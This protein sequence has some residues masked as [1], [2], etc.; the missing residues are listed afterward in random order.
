M[1]TKNTEIRAEWHG[2]KKA[3]TFQLLLQCGKYAK[4]DGAS[5]SEL[6]IDVEKK[7]FQA[8]LWRGK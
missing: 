1:T 2:K 5:Q 8:S 3:Q 4:I 6:R 7:S